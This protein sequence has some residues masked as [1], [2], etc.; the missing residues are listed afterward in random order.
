MIFLI[1][2]I[3]IISFKKY[4]NHNNNSTNKFKIND[5]K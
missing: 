1:N 4:E 3:K 5:N 2:F